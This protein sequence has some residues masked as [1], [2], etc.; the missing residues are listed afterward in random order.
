MTRLTLLL[1]RWSALLPL[2]LIRVLGAMFG[3]ILYVLAT[4]RRR[5]ARINL[6]LCF[7]ELSE[8]ARNERL[9]AHF[10]CFAQSIFD[11]GLLWH[12]SAERLRRLIKTEGSE[13]LESALADGRPVILLGPHF[14]GM[15]AGWTRL[16]LDRR[17]VSM[18]ANQ[19]NP[20]FNTAMR[21][22][23]VRFNNPLALSRQEGIRAAVKALRSGMP[24]YYLPD[25]DFGPRDAIFVPFFGV[26]AATVPG[27][28]RI[29]ALANAI[30]IP[31]VTR[32][33]SQGYTLKFHPA[34][35]D[36]PGDD[37][38]AATRRMNAFIE[39]QVRA[40]PDQ[41]L[42]LHKRFKTRPAGEK[43]FYRK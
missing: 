3:A 8:A 33:T 40:M 20:R 24:F 4:E 28:A 26:P 42:W 23:R 41:Y 15:D 31:S 16:S 17:L 13:I 14:V 12:A 29:A 10:R 35:E 21:A 25:M 5:I 43:S 37:L 19:K 30:V 38:E 2:P 39:D 7:P 11:R 36:Y 32:M 22:G 6:R 27:I 1:L 9:R 34:W 18:Y